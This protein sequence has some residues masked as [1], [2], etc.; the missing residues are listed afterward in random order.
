M[1][2]WWNDAVGV[3][4]VSSPTAGEQRGKEERS[5]HDD[6]KKEGKAGKKTCRLWDYDSA[7]QGAKQQQQ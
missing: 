5:R 1:C 3:A 7:S 2:L 4:K 6:K